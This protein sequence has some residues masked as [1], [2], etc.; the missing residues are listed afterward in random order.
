MA[1]KV[2]KAQMTVL[3][4]QRDQTV[5]ELEHLR[6]ELKAEFEMD[7]VDD[8]A[9]DLVERDKMQALIFAL[10]RRLED[11]NH[12]IQQAEEVGYGICEKCGKVIDPE[13]LEIFP[14]TTLCID[15][16]RESERRLF[17]T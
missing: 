1:K 9:S 14:E 5:T 16:K 7:D 15:C 11:I 2:T 17:R 6:E 3:E 13:R 8:I 4:K 10:E 12:A